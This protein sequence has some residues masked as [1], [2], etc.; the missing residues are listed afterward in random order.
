MIPET[1]GDGAKEIIWSWNSA[2][3]YTSTYPI[4]SESL[5]VDPR[6]LQKF[7]Q[8]MFQALVMWQA[9]QLVSGIHKCHSPDFTKLGQYLQVSNPAFQLEIRG[10]KSSY[11]W[12]N[13]Q[14]SFL[15]FLSFP[16][17]VVL[18]WITILRQVSSK[19]QS[20]LYDPITCPINHLDASFTL[21]WASPG[22]KYIV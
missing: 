18:A 16:V 20:Q 14:S 6:N 1:E 22:Q 21:L 11:N 19:Q 10:T 17:H 15:E 4:Q 5:R 3:P 8:Q 12:L 7:I 2:V 9:L 13:R